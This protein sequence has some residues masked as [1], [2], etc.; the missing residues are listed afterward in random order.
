MVRLS[1]ENITSGHHSK[2]TIFHS[3]AM[4]LFIPLSVEVTPKI[5]FTASFRLFQTKLGFSDVLS[6]RL[7]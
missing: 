7:T 5:A 1:L 6:V 4:I 3:I 2:G